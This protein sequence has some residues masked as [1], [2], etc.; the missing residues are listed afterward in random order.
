MTKIFNVIGDF[1][2]SDLYLYIFYGAL[3]VA[4]GLIIS[5]KI[6]EFYIERRNNKEF[7]RLCDKYGIEDDYRAPDY[8]WDHVGYL[9][10][11]AERYEL[12]SLYEAQDKFNEL[13]ASHWNYIK[14]SEE[15][16]RKLQSLDPGE[17][18]FVL[19]ALLHGEGVERKNNIEESNDV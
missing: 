12:D 8:V 4:L 10:Q 13:H 5:V 7:V 15:I 11:L 3:G 2:V 6:L 1:L 19:R 14:C 9:I 17:R 16:N 18:V